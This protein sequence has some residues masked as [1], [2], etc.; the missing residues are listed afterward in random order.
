MEA[1]LFLICPSNEDPIANTRQVYLLK[2]HVSLKAFLY[3]FQAQPLA[4]LLNVLK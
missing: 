2:A 1:R 3:C 4:K